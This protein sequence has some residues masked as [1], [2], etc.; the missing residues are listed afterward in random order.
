MEVNGPRRH[1]LSCRSSSR[2]SH[3]GALEALRG[4]MF[5]I[6]WVVRDKGLGIGRVGIGQGIV[7]AARIG[8]I[9]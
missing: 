1:A 2:V 7:N 5:D 9:T 8:E 3:L 6:V 4:I